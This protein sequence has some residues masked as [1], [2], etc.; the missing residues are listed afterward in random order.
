MNFISSLCCCVIAL[1]H[2]LAHAGELVAEPQNPSA[3][4]FSSPHPWEGWTVEF[5]VAWMTDNCIDDFILGQANIEEGPAGAETYQITATKT[6]RELPFQLLGHE[7]RPLLELPLCLEFVDQNANDDFF[8][9]N[10]AFQ[11]R[12]VDFPWNHRLNTS[13]GAGLGLSYASRLYAMDRQR[14]PN[15]DRSHLK[16]NLPIFVSFA[17]PEIPEHQVRFYIA[18]HSGGFGIFDEGGVNSLGVSYA[19]SF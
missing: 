1:T 17:L 5:G 15:E 3:L 14:H 11:L 12:W 19:Y 9:S 4:E 13:F 2:P 18:H 8:V 7:F 16:F 10:F 6:L